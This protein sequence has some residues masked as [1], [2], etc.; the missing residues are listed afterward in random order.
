[1]VV[2]VSY[3]CALLVVSFVPDS[4]PADLKP[5]LESGTTFALAAVLLVALGRMGPRGGQEHYAAAR[6]AALFSLVFFLNAFVRA[7]L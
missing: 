4:A 3:S 2:V 7:L 5:R 6:F 1:V